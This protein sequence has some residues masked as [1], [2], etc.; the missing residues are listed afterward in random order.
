M[1]KRSDHPSR[2][3]LRLAGQAD[4]D[5][6]ALADTALWLAR[7]ME[8]DVNLAPY[9]RHLD[10]LSEDVRRYI[11]DDTDDAPLALEA[12]RQVISRRYGYGGETDS[13]ERH[14][15]ATL[16]R[17]VD[18]RR[19]NALVLCVL[20]AHVLE[21]NGWPVEILDFTARPLI[22][23]R[24]SGQR[25]IVD[26]FAGGRLVSARDLRRLLQQHASQAAALRPDSLHALSNRAALMALMHEIKMHHLRHASPEAALHALEG[27]LLMAPQAA[28][29]W[30]E[31]GL[32]HA[33]LD[34]LEDAADALERFLQLPGNDVH[35]YTA[36]Q[37]L[38]QLRL[39][40]QREHT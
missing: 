8:P 17:A 25:L 29:L 35:R 4:D 9:R 14:F 3:A 39:R 19:A 21:T 20:Y 15:A 38:Q 6:V 36:S 33:R 37:M 11:A 28:D 5:A 18:R 12:A 27:T 23:L 34:H 32:L 26:P 7:W 24:A 13:E 30:R 31:L 10:Q 16:T 22:S 40:I 2:D 1:A